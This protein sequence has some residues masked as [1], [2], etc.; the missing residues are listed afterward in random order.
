MSK[1]QVEMFSPLASPLPPLGEGEVLSPQQWTTLMSI[2]D[3]LIASIDSPTSDMPAPNR[4][5]ISSAE[6]SAAVQQLEAGLPQHDDKD[7]VQTY[8]GESVSQNPRARE[9]LHRT[10][11]E[12]VRPD[13]RKGMA[14]LL[15]ALE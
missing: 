12:Y 11:D 14:V 3:A 10:L 7:L 4:L 9:L 8:L 2:G 6:Y 5:S 15:A 13:V 1:A